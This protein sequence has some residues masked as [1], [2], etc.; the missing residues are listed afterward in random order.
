VVILRLPAV[1]ELVADTDWLNLDP[2]GWNVEAG[3]IE[4]VH[5]G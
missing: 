2:G 4:L 5:I 1:F 3:E